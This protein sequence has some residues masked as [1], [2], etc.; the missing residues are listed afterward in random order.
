M[1]RSFAKKTI[2]DF[3]N[4]TTAI[5]GPNGSGKSNVAE[6]FRFEKALDQEFDAR[7][8]A[9]VVVREDEPGPVR[10]RAFPNGAYVLGIVA[11]LEID[12]IDEAARALRADSDPADIDAAA[13]DVSVKAVAHYPEVVSMMADSLDWTT[14][15]GQAYAWQPDDVIERW[16][17]ETS[18][19]DRNEAVAV[20]PPCPIAEPNR[21]LTF[22]RGIVVYAI[23][24]LLV[25]VFA[26]YIVVQILRFQSI[27]APLIDGPL[28]T[29][30]AGDA[31]THEP[32][33]FS[34]EGPGPAAGIDEM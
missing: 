3:S 16:R 2:L 34:R 28:V 12:E 25:V 5:V 8:I 18:I 14:A 26:G 19:R 29:T 22:S 32:D 21:G 10:P 15:L 31:Q 11:H 17:A 4:A 6:A 1:P 33:A 9:E 13:W 23:L 20:A 30:L 24:T 27:S 7:R